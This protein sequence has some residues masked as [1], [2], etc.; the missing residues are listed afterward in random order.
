MRTPRAKAG[1]RPQTDHESKLPTGPL[2]GPSET[3]AQETVV[4]LLAAAFSPVLAKRS[5]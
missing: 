4:R 1:R 3:Y 5:E 2:V